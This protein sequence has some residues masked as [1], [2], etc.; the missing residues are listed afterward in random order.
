MARR[1]VMA[2]RSQI[3]ILAS[4]TVAG[5]IFE[6]LN[7]VPEGKDSF[8]T[9]KVSNDGNTYYFYRWGLWDENDE[10]DVLATGV[11]AILNS[12]D[13]KVKTDGYWFVRNGDDRE[14]WEDF[15]V[16]SGSL[17]GEL[18][19]D[20]AAAG[21]FD[22]WRDVDADGTIHEIDVMERCRAEWKKFQKAI[23]PYGMKT[24]VALEQAIGAK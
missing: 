3:W 11:N 20:G 22:D 24:V 12:V 19:S 9:I 18:Y 7:T 1:Y 13:E 6:F 21:D 5:R 4:K 2:Y 17:E 8:E 23:E 15:S 16:N 14:D 10:S